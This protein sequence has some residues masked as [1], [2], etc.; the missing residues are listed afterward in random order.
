MNSS[1]KCVEIFYHYINL[2]QAD[3]YLHIYYKMYISMLQFQL[4]DSVKYFPENDKSQSQ[5]G[6]LKFVKT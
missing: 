3:K 2:S 6:Q 4:Y 1:L 5:S